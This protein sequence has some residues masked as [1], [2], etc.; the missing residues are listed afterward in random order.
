M[1]AQS[2]IETNEDGEY[3]CPE[4]GELVTDARLHVC[5]GVSVYDHSVSGS[6]VTLAHVVDQRIADALERIADALE[7]LTGGRG[8]A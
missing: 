4:C 8:S 7:G 6:T 3:L 1:M 5:G 2:Y